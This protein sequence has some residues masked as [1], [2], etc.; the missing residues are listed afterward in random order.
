MLMKQDCFFK[1]PCSMGASQPD[2]GVFAEA[3]EAV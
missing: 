3:K 2:M 1:A